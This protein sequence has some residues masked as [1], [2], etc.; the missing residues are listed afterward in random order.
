MD[1]HQLSELR[2]DRWSAN[3]AIYSF[4]PAVRD[5][6]YRY[7]HLDEGSC[8]WG[9]ARLA[10]FPSISFTMSLKMYL[11]RANHVKGRIFL[12]FPRANGSH[13][14]HNA[15][16]NHRTRVFL[17]LSVLSDKHS[18]RHRRRASEEPPSLKL[19][20]K[21]KKKRGGQVL[22]LLLFDGFLLCWTMLL[23]V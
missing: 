8:C 10:C 6:C 20:K 13:D 17:L 22:L 5:D 18:R 21:K 11:K 1:F 14:T 12:P 9:G 7:T 15:A 23:T 4:N 16:P 2:R 3:S 19:R